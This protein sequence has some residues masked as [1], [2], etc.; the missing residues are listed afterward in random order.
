MSIFKNITIM[1]IILGL[2]ACNSAR[3]EHKKGRI[4]TDATVQQTIDSLTELYGEGQLARMRKGVEQAAALWTH[5]DGTADDFTT[6]CVEQF[7]NDAEAR[8][9]L[10]EALSRNFEALWGHNNQISVELNKPLHLDWGPLQPVDMIF[11]GYSPMAH[12]YDDFFTNKI[13]FTTILNFPFYSLQDKSEMSTSWTRTEWAYARMGDV[14][15]SRVPAAISQEIS[16]IA[17]ASDGYISDYN[18]PMDQLRDNTGN[19]LFPQ[20]MKLISHWGLRD[21]IKS[22]YSMQDALPKQE[23][24]YQ[25]MLR[26]IHQDIPEMVINNTEVQWNPYTNVV[27]QNHQEVSFEREPDT[28]YEQLLSNFRAHKASD[29]YHPNY[30]TYI[31]RAFDQG[32]ELSMEEVEEL[33]VELVSSP[34]LVDVGKLITQRLGRELRPYDIWYDGF[35]ARSSISEEHLDNL[36]RQRYP[37]AAALDRD[38]PNLLV[39]LGYEPTRAAY[40]ADK[41]VVEASRGAGHAWPASMRS[42]QSRLRTRIP[43]DGMD[44]KGFNIAIHELGHNV[45]QTV[46]LYDVD[47]YMLRSVPNTAFTEALAFMY[48]TRDLQLLGIETNEPN[49]E[50]LNTLDKFWGSYEIMGVSLVDMAVWRWMYANPD[51]TPAQLREETIRIANEVWNNFFAPV[52]GEEDQPIL[53]IYSHMIS[54]PLYLSAY[55]LGRL[56][57]FQI[58]QY[59]KG[60]NMAVETDRMFT[61]GGL[62]PQEWME[63]AVGQPISNQPMLDAVKVALENL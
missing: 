27:L 8:H 42:Q 50:Y 46:S 32:L 4:L 24:I 38:L 51:A 12:F 29:S 7:V 33:F 47:Y 35:K 60:K 28:R 39:K 48:Q 55:P 58:E 61:T 3:D 17:T 20:G 26:I 11:A 23:I 49:V 57:E 10:F 9:K 52:F 54:Y 13:A 44:Y 36:T 14:F 59:I 56:I 25:V 18:I 22:N 63:I 19:T 2:A 6:F 16:R 41:I 5:K 30:P 43:A 40:I 37:D 53:A 45:E 1:A 31:L 21:E 34:L 62:I 15:I